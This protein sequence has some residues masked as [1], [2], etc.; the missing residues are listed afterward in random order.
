VRNQPSTF[1]PGI[2]PRVF[3]THFEVDL[4]VDRLA[5]L[6]DGNSVTALA[7][8]ALQE[9]PHPMAVDGADGPEGPPGPLGP[10]GPAGP[11]ATVRRVTASGTQSTALAAC[12]AD[13]ALVSGG[14]SCSTTIL[15]SAPSGNGWS[16]RCKGKAAATATALCI[17]K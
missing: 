15:G 12:A 10:A 3:V 6:L 2:H 5:W 8:F 17:R 16:V 1:L 9:C 14:G 11:G 7:F 4:F 13:E